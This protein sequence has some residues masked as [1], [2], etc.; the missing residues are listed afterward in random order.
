LLTDGSSGEGHVSTK[1]RRHG[2]GR[3]HKI[4]SM[5]G[6]LPRLSSEAQD[7]TLTVPSYIERT[8]SHMKNNSLAVTVSVAARLADLLDEVAERKLRT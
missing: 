3:E 5:P 2:N 7:C 4:V 1:R 8:G 6:L